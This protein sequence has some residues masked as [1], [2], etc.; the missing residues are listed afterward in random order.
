MISEEIAAEVIAD[1]VDTL[2]LEFL[3]GAKV[4]CE[5]LRILGLNC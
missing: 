1:L 4:F 3:L 2:Q 5:H